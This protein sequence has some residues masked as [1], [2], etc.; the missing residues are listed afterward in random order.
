MSGMSALTL[1]LS[2]PAT[3]M[4]AALAQLTAF[5][6]RESY[7]FLQTC[8]HA[9]HIDMAI[10]QQQHCC[11]MLSIYAARVEGLTWVAPHLEALPA[12]VRQLIQQ[13]KQVCTA[14]A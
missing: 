12:E 6:V 3:Q 2:L 9:G 10:F 13:V 7:A 4:S 5:L 1:T 14:T 11:L 8:H